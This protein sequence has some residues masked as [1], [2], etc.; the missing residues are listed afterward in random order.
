[1][2]EAIRFYEALRDVS[3]PANPKLFLILAEC[4]RYLHEDVKAFDYYHRVLQVDE[5]NNRARAQIIQMLDDRG[6]VDEAMK[7]AIIAV[8]RNGRAHLEK[9]NLSF[10]IP[11]DLRKATGSLRKRIYRRRFKGKANPLD[12]DSLESKEIREMYMSLCALADRIDQGHDDLKDEWQ[13]LADELIEEFQQSEHQMKQAWDRNVARIREAKRAQEFTSLAIGLTNDVPSLVPTI[14]EQQDVSRS[15]GIPL[16]KWAEIYARYGVYLALGGNESD[17]FE[18]FNTVSS[19]EIV[20][21]TTE[22]LDVV[23]TGR[24]CKYDM[25]SNILLNESDMVSDSLRGIL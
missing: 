2:G 9:L 12:H 16:E 8:K 17:C 11:E 15:F 14:T 4:H 6:E 7:W 22:C 10:D 24:L 23:N 25:C 3:K 21:R 20:Y 1:V 19:Y 5:N 18:M 13:A